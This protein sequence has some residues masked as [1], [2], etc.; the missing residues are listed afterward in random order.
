MIKTHFP[1][2]LGGQ[3]FVV[4]TSCL[5]VDSLD[6]EGLSIQ[7]MDE[8]MFDFVAI[9]FTDDEQEELIEAC[10]EALDSKQSELDLD[11]VH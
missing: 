7:T 9:D 8:E 5:S 4:L 2:S 11:Y 3:N 1:Y 10:I 6:V